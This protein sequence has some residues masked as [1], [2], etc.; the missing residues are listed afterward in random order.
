MIDIHHHLIF[1]VDDGARS[2][3]TSIQMVEMA[4]SDG[5]T[6]IACTPHAIARFPYQFEVNAERRALIAERT[7]NKVVLGQG[8][9]FHLTQE[10][11]DDALQ[12]PTKYTINGRNY[13]LVEF[14]E[15]YI[16][17]AMTE[18][19]HELIVAG[20][21]PVLTHP[22]RNPVLQ[23]YPERM[24]P[25]I[26]LGCLVQ[27][28]ANSLSGRF[29]RI[30]QKMAYHLLDQGRVHLLATDAHNTDSR[31]PILSE[32]RKLVAERYGEALAEQLCQTNP[33]AVF[34]GLPLPEPQ[35]AQK[36]HTPKHGLLERIFGRKA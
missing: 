27:I 29:G 18:N 21:R 7:Q 28:T 14:D 10:N 20:A 34:D 6:H 15:Q 5:I 32:A 16:S 31:P 12:N 4:A 24:Q 9:D 17:P 25:W 3:E 35:V 26:E 13:L 1:G 2:L 33:Q 30:A 11:I 23:R 36:V 22:E 8:C 19:F